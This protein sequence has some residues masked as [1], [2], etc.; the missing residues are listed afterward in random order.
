MLRIALCQM[1]VTA[2]KQ[3]NLDQAALM[4]EK[5]ARDGAQ[6]AVLPEMFNCPYDIHCFRD[7]A[8][9]IPSG[10]TTVRLA[11][12][13][14]AHKLFLVGGSIPEL[15]GE[16]LYNT[17]V[18]FNPRGEIIVKHQK[19][20]LFDVCVKNGIKFTESEVLAP[21]N[22]A[23]IFETPWGKF[24]V[25]ICYDIRFP[26]LTRKMAKNG[27]NVVFVPAAFNMTTGPAHWELL[28]CS[29]A[30]DNQIFMLGG[31]PARDSQSSYVAYGHSLA[32]DP[33]GQVMA[34]LDE[35]PGILLVDLDLAQINE[36]REAIPVWR[37]RREDLY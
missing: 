1:L 33:W 29:R 5:A 3:E 35:K 37:Q 16:L 4:L 26:E 8:E 20:H 23:T 24:G 18:V 27:A 22:S 11:E 28:F 34:Q 2:N 6:L 17:C 31:S 14:Q 7:Y 12:L 32:V 10:E 9:T 25:E 21:G 15:A 30:L 13:A 36:T 19:V